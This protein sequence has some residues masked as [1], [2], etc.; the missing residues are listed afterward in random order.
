MIQT[1]VAATLTRCS[2]TGLVCARIA[3]EEDACSFASDLG[4]DGAAVCRYGERAALAWP[5]TITA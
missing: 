2:R 5:I 1:A 3:A 4:D